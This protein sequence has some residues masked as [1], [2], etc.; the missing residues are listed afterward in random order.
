MRG[1]GNGHNSEMSETLAMLA[2]SAAGGGIVS[3]VAFISVKEAA[4]LEGQTV[5]GDGV[6]DDT[7]GIQAA[8]NLIAGTGTTLWFPAGTYKT[9]SPLLVSSQSRA[10]ID[11]GATIAGSVGIVG[12][13]KNAVFQ[14]GDTSVLKT[15]LASTPTFGSKTFAVVSAAG[16]ASGNLIALTSAV[17]TGQTFTYVIEKLVGT[18]VTTDRPLLM[19]WAGGDGVALVTSFPSNVVL[20]GKGTISGIADTLVYLLGAQ[21]CEV[22]DLTLVPTGA[23]TYGLL[24]D[25]GGYR[26]RSRGLRVEANGNGDT[27]TSFAAAIQ[28]VCNQGTTLDEPAAKNFSPAG[29][30]SCGVAFLNCA[31]CELHAPDVTGCLIGILF[32]A[33]NDT[34]PGCY[35]CRCVG[36]SSVA[37]STG[38]DLAFSTSYCSV[39]GTDISFN[40]GNGVLNETGSVANALVGCKIRGNAA[41]GVNSTG[42]KLSV[43]ACDL[44][45]NGTWGAEISGGSATFSGT[46][47]TDANGSGL[48]IF[49]A[50]TVEVLVS[51]TLAALGT[52]YGV[53][54]QDGTLVVVDGWRS[55]DGGTVFFT[56]TASTAAKLTLSNVALSG[57][58]TIG[59][60][61]SA[62][63]TLRIQHDVNLSAAA[64]QFV[65]AGNCNRGTFNSSNGMTAVPFPDL[66]FFDQVLV[67]PTAAA[68]TGWLSAQ[69]AG[70]GF[71][72]TDTGVHVYDYV[73]L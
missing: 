31:E 21:S 9:T 46:T 44:D 15:T 4:A 49:A 7:S 48:F 72:W 67:M 63:C 26:N 14:A 73:I 6:H 34:S 69:T 43:T 25:L 1:H 22:N 52:G 66:H 42:D 61:N 60:D 8:L 29:D 13:K 30:E 64:T 18:T 71:V 24:F 2:L 23:S 11:E 28:V 54:E 40:S 3:N 51:D 37:N 56:T 12:N 19:P 59:A 57:A 45:G 50:G 10:W 20:E 32:A 39:I 70:T 27:V 58:P 55:S 33:F 62:G 38:F 68:A 53:F 16:L 36:G 41:T 35:A 17:N 47:C 5:I 65:N